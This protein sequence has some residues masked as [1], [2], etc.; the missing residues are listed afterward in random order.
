MY[1]KENL[2]LPKKQN[3]WKKNNNYSK[4]IYRFTLRELT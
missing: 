3:I 2:K 1:Q 4:N